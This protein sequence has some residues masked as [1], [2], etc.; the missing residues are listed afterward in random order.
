MRKRFVIMIMLIAFS[1]CL[2]ACDKNSK[3]SVNSNNSDGGNSS[4]AVSVSVA[5]DEQLSNATDFIHFYD[6]DSINTD[7]KIVITVNEQIDGFEF[8]ELDESDALSIGKTL[9]QAQ[10]PKIGDAYIFHTYINDATLN[11]AVSYK[12]KNGQIKYFG[13]ECNMNNGSVS[14]KE[15]EF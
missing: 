7:W 13:I 6:R 9:Y 5:T 3:A 8:L 11:R 15:I 2:C 12:D 10:F 1:L 14:L 4:I